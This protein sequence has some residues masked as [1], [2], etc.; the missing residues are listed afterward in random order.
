VLLLNNLSELYPLDRKG[1]PF[2][3]QYVLKW[4]N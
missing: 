4:S 2:P 3:E 1:T